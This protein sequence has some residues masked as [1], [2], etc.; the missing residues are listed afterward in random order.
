MEPST[1]PMEQTPPSPAEAQA[2]ASPAPTRRFPYIPLLSIIVLL[3]L[4][5]AGFLAYQNMKLLKQINAP[6]TYEECVT[7]SGS[8]IQE[9]YPATCVTAEGLRFTQPIPITPIPT[10]AANQQSASPESY[11]ACGC[12]CCGGVAPEKQ[13]L[14]RSKGDTL[15]QV[16]ADDM[17]LKQSPS[18][19]LMGCGLGKTYSYCD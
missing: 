11:T 8:R 2:L 10:I 12:G 13:C 9:S 17:E 5:A 19:K 15:E 3:L 4:A 7:A 14:Y 16:I 6:K 18:C 1:P